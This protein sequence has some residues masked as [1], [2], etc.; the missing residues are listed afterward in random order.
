MVAEARD[1]YISLP[2]HTIKAGDIP[3]VRSAPSNVPDISVFRKVLEHQTQFTVLLIQ[4]GMPSAECDYERVVGIRYIPSYSTGHLFR[5][6]LSDGGHVY[7][8]NVGTNGITLAIH[9][10]KSGHGELLYK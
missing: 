6:D 10:R 2:W 7:I 8:W 3:E 1:P 5:Y 4:C 9:Q